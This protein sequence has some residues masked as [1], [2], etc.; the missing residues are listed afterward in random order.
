MVSDAEDKAVVAFLYKEARPNGIRVNIVAPGLVETEMGFRLAKATQG[1]QDMREL[2]SK[3][4]F[5]RVCQ[6]QDIANVVRFLVS[7]AASYVTGTQLDVDGGM[8]AYL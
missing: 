1:I 7:D 2:D 4:P 6:P 3:M 8:A 5:S